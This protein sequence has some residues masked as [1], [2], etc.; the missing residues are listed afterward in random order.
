MAVTR[1][2]V[3]LRKSLVNGFTQGSEGYWKTKEKIVYYATL[4]LAIIKNIYKKTGSVN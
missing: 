1:G 3:S 2:V 4:V